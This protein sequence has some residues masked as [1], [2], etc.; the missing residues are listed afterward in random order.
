LCTNL[1]SFQANHPHES[2]RSQRLIPSLIAQPEHD[3]WFTGLSRV[4]PNGT[5]E[6]LVRFQ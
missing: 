1:Q 3:E 6:T 4:L 5:S 2:A